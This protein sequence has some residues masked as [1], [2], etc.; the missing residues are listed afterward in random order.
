M[1]E[2]ELSARSR[3]ISYNIYLATLCDII[4]E[5]TTTDKSFWTPYKNNNPNLILE[6][7]IRWLD[8]SKTTT[9]LGSQLQPNSI[10][11][12]TVLNAATQVGNATLIN[13]IW[14]MAVQHSK[15]DSNPLIMKTQLY[16]AMLLFCL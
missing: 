7:A 4:V 14:D 12:S 9:L 1:D 10:S 16:N 15:H 8:S 6:E 3:K 2:K 13:Q 5:K 11:Y